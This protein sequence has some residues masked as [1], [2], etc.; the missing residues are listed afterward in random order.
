M[1]QFTTLPNNLIETENI[2]L[3]HVLV[4]LMCKKYMNHQSRM[5]WPSITTLMRECGIGR[6]RI[7]N[8]LN[9]LEKAG[10]LHIQHANI[11][12]QSNQ[13]YFPPEKED[14]FEM[15][16]MSLINAK[17]FS[18]TEKGYFAI[19][20]K[21]YFIDKDTR[22]G[23]YCLTNNQIAE[24]TG[25]SNASISR[26]E[27]NLIDKDVVARFKTNVK[28]QITGLYKNERLTDLDKSKQADVLLAEDLNSVKLM[29]AAMYKEM[30]ST[31]S[32]MN[33][34]LEQIEVNQKQLPTSFEFENKESD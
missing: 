4:Y 13:Y 14:K 5:A 32:K 2:K 31:M 1:N 3:Q 23:K 25:L 19:L 8:A 9:D 26:L 11:K 10:F 17:E 30:R 22:T 34:R 12:G 21:F 6:N 16:S 15:I 7:V 27:K 28:D 18:P 33:K 24:L 29:M 20:Q